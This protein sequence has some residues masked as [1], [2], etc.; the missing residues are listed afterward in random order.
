MSSDN[1]ALETSGAS[2]PYRVAASSTNCSSR[3]GMPSRRSRDGKARSRRLRGPT[4]SP[5]LPVAAGP[6]WITPIIRLTPAVPRP[7]LKAFGKSDQ[8]SAGQ[9]REVLAED[10]GSLERRTSLT[11]NGGLH[12]F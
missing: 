2:R 10:L 4:P 9:R 6:A 3:M 12:L 8:D 1:C 7:L 5:L 11:T